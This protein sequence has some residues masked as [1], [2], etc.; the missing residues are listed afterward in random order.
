MIVAIH[1]PNFF[2]W[3]GFFDKIARADCFCLLDSV[4][5]P[6]TGGTYSNRVQLR[7]GTKAAWVTAPVDRTYSGLRAIREMH[8]SES[9]PWRERLLR[10]IQAS[11]GRAPHFAEVF[12]LLAPLVRNPSSNL[13]DYNESA[14]RAL[15]TAL[16]LDTSRIVRS[17]SLDVSG[18]STDLLVGITRALG[19][20]AYLCGGGAGGYQQ[21]ERFSAAGLHLLP[22][23]FEHPVYPQAGRGD[24]LRGLSVIDALMNV[25]FEQTS[26]M[27]RRGHVGQRAA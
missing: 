27:L 2:P 19:G 12:E 4:Q 15:G 23:Q 11:Y 9:V 16:G 20:T 3:L 18:A 21:D 5:F 7:L 17:S 14:L 13:A 26:Q 8:F 25:G 1:Q 22:Q 10:T 24:F 6:K